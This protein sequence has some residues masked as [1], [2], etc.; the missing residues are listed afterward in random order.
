MAK[1]RFGRVAVFAVAVSLVGCGNDSSS[2]SASNPKRNV[3]VSTAVSTTTRPATSTSATTTTAFLG[4]STTQPAADPGTL[5]TDP[6]PGVQTHWFVDPAFPIADVDTTVHL[7][8]RP[9]EC[10]GDTE[11]IP[12]RP[13]V[14]VVAGEIRITI[15]LAPLP[16]PDLGHGNCTDPTFPVVVDL[17]MPIDGRPLV[18]A[19]C[20]LGGNRYVSNPHDLCVQRP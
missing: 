6:E 14:R 1:S 13:G 17:G 15:D 16:D 4:P 19:T 2:T 3:A 12:L 20:L 10:A 7:F 18:D 11:R 9:F 5:A 8:V